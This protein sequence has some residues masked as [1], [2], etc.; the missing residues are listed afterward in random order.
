[1][2]A[3][4]KND[5]FDILLNSTHNH[6][7]NLATIPSRN[8][9]T[10]GNFTLVYWLMFSP[11]LNL[12]DNWICVTCVF[13]FGGN[14]SLLWSATMKLLKWFQESFPLVAQHWLILWQEL[15]GF[16]RSLLIICCITTLPLNLMSLFLPLLFGLTFLNTFRSS[17]ILNSCI[18]KSLAIC[19][20]PDM[21]CWVFIKLPV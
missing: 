1:M 19:I 16:C 10:S 9:M 14:V 18:R 15:Q 6:L 2:R 4:L 11:H 5:G 12:F 7:H 17:T 21:I 20:F 8:I 13:F 3:Y